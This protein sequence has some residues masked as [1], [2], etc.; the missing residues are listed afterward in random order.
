M[1]VA[2]EEI[3]LSKA[4]VKS[5]NF[6]L[7]RKFRNRTADAIKSLR[8]S[9]KYKAIRDRLVT[10]SDGAL[11]GR[12]PGGR[13][14]EE[15]MEVV[16]E[17]EALASDPHPLGEKGETL[18]SPELDGDQKGWSGWSTPIPKSRRGPKVR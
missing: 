4:G 14:H 6:D 13:E 8:R 2:R 11:T 3:R 15:G 9:A 16:R 18:S 17:D 5:V 10:E 1:L 7:F 12:L